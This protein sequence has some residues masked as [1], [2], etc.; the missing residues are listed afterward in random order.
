MEQKGNYRLAWIGKPATKM[1]GWK[2]DIEKCLS[3]SFAGIELDFPGEEKKKP[4]RSQSCTE[5]RHEIISLCSLRLLW[6]GFYS[7][8]LL[9]VKNL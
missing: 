5:K 2:E 6:R 3:F 4:Q 1:C 8:V 7:T 9:S